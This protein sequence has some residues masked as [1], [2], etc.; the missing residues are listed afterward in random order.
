MYIVI[1]RF[2]TIFDLSKYETKH[3]Q[4]EEDTDNTT[5][6]QSEYT[7]SHKEIF[8]NFINIIKGKNDILLRSTNVL[9]VLGSVT[10]SKTHKQYFFVAFEL[11][12]FNC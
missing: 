2:K 10:V 11:N 9:H 4:L 5:I 6:D 8:F 12:F 3:D 1:F 7:I